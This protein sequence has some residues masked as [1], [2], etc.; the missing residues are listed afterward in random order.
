MGQSSLKN[1]LDEIMS[2]QGSPL[3][4]DRHTTKTKIY[5]DYGGNGLKV[6]PHVSF[7]TNLNMH[8]LIQPTIVSP[9]FTSQS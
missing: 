7:M 9:Y 8:A 6:V 4:G 5:I 3:V 2:F 1:M